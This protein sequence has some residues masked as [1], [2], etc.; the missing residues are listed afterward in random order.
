LLESEMPP[1][2]LLIECPSGCHV[3]AVTGLVVAP[4]RHA[5]ED[6]AAGS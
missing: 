1:E 5:A 3:I 6:G 2:R 4:V